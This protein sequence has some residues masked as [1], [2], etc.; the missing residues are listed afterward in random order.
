MKIKISARLVLISC[1]LLFAIPVV[2][3][4]EPMLSAIHTLVNMIDIPSQKTAEVQWY[5][6]YQITVVEKEK[7]QFSVSIGRFAGEVLTL[8]MGMF[9][10]RSITIDDQE[11]RVIMIKTFDKDS[12]TSANAARIIFN[13]AF[14]SPDIN[15]KNDLYLQYSKNE[16]NC[17]QLG[18]NSPL[19]DKQLIS[20]VASFAGCLQISDIPIGGKFSPDLNEQVLAALFTFSIVVESGKKGP[21]EGKSW[22]I[23]KVE[24]QKIYLQIR[25]SGS[26]C[27]DQYKVILKRL[28]EG[29][30]Q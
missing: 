17:N 22:K 13:S 19:C 8:E 14:I 5:Q 16:H 4:D 9:E 24:D 10:S 29:S 18:E 20:A 30:S 25:K 2:A 27:Q 6:K 28:S 21:A 23:G 3:G 12:Q 1:L 7:E 11:I 26:Q 15:D